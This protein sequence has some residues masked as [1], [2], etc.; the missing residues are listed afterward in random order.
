MVSS[1]PTSIKEMSECGK[2]REMNKTVPALG[3]FIFLTEGTLDLGVPVSCTG[4][5][6]LMGQSRHT[7]AGREGD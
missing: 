3:S 6:G 1:D 2:E 4:L 7:A 5:E